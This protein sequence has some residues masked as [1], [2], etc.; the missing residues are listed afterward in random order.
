M[1]LNWKLLG[2]RIREVRIGK[3]L[4]QE[5]LAEKVGVSSVYISH[6]E[7]G[8]SKSSLETLVKI[9]NALETTPDYLLMNSLYSSKNQLSDK[10]GSQLK[11]CTSKD[12][13]FISDIIKVV[14]EHK[15]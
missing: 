8:T 7:V 4:T 3:N 9:C 14:I 2:R 6:I 5:A 1:E 13:E 15:K 12:I 10:I 11:N